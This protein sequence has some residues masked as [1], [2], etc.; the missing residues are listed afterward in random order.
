MKF[1]KLFPHVRE[2]EDV[3]LIY[4]VI[5]RRST[6]NKCVVCGDQT[7][8]YDLSEDRYLCSQSCADTWYSSYAEF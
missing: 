1:D 8:W 5:T 2:Q 7:S 3:D 4:T 6:E